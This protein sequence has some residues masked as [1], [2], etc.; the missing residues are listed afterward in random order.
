MNLDA[1]LT[2]LLGNNH[3]TLQEYIGFQRALRI[4]QELTLTEVTNATI[5]SSN[6][7]NDSNSGGGIFATTE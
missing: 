5:T 3:I 4:E 7:R 1:K 2:E 6:K